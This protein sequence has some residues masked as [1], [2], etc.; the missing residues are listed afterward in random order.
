MQW[1]IPNICRMYRNF[2]DALKNIRTKDTM[3]NKFKTVIGASVISLAM[4]SNA[5]HAATE[6]ASAEAEIIAAVELSA[7]T[8]LDMGLVAVGA[9]GGTVTLDEASGNRTCSVDLTCVGTAARGSFQVTNAADG[10]IVDITVDA[11]TTLTGAGAPMNLSLTPST[12]AITFDST[13]LETVFVGG[14]LT[15]GASQAAGVYTG[16]YSVSAD[17]Q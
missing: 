15:V 13:A 9:A 14:E 2:C 17:Y 11:S 12:T 1:G 10:L 7:V 5:A 3:L 4:M 8:D 6:T 16:T